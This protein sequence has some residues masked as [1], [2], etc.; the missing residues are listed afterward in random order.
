MIEKEQIIEEL[1]KKIKDR[2]VE[3]QKLLRSICD[4]IFEEYNKGSAKAA[5]LFLQG[6]ISPLKT[7]FD[8]A[9]NM[10]LKKMGI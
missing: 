4:E 3:E 5:S 9:H 1:E 6:K 2:D 7:K 8:D 10:L